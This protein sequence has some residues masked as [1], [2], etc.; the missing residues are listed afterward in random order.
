MSGFRLPFISPLAGST[1]SNM[2][3]VLKG[4]RV[5]PQ[6]YFKVV[7]T[8]IFIP[9]SSAF[10]WLDRLFLAK[11]IRNYTF[12]ESPVFIIG[13]WRSGTTFLHNVLCTAPAFGYVNTYQSVFPL[14][15][16]SS[17][18]F[19]T[20]M[21]I[22]MPSKRPG[23]GMKISVNLPQED[24]YA[25]SNI[26][27][28]SFYHFFYF[29]SNYTKYYKQYV[30]FDQ[31]PEDHIDSWKLDYRKLVIEAMLNSKGRRAL[32]KNP[33]NTG[34]M[35][36]LIDVFPDAEFIF[37]IRNP[38]IVY[39][40]SKKFFT[41]LFP[42]VNLEIFSSDE[43]NMMILDLYE[44]LM[45]DYISDK[46]LVGK[47]RIV[48]IRYE[49]FEENPLEIIQGL[50]SKFSWKKL[51]NPNPIFEDFLAKQEKHKACKYSISRQELDMVL[52]RI[53]FAMKYWDYT[54]PSN[55]EIVD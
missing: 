2:T 12:K 24:E 38:I 7:V 15:L 39:L 36:I 29:P 8:F 42:A 48:E 51:R 37:M 6:Y 33:V 50:Y 19:K 34:R 44:R 40:S 1:L 26:T 21:R 28:R 22:F 49:D 23:D 25:L 4:N 3:R 5:A 41:Q 45:K 20:F 55:L 27:H 18:I 46:G 10:H 32:L 9:I 16:K 14:N 52:P 43:I 35:K 11:K 47:D 54:L 17:W 53:D 30:R 13:H 31:Q